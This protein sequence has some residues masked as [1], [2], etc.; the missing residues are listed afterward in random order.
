M[1][2][3]NKIVYTGKVYQNNNKYTYPAVFTSEGNGT[4]SVNFSDLE[5][6]YTR[7]DNLTDSIMMAE[8]VFVFVLYG[9]ERDEKQIPTLSKTETIKLEDG[10]FVNYIVCDM[11]VYRKMHSNKS[12]KKMFSIPEWLNKAVKKA[13]INLS[14]TL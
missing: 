9:Y 8:D 13:G 2:S 3:G 11:L 14:G 6:C 12:V 7:G 10:A 1:Q 4:Y 5:R